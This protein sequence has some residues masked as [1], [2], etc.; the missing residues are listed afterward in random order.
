M[1]KMFG[2]KTDVTL[3]EFNKVY[4][5]AINSKNLTGL[6]RFKND[7]GMVGRFFGLWAGESIGNTILPGLGGKIMGGAAGEMASTALPGLVRRA[8]ESII[9]GGGNAISGAAKIGLGTN[10]QPDQNQ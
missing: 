3:P 9:S 7:S 8:G 6:A 4:S 2:G 5:N 1:S 10:N